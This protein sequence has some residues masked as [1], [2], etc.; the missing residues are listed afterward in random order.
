M[1]QEAQVKH[2]GPKGNTKPVRSRA[3]CGTLNNWTVLEYDTITQHFKDNCSKW[4][5]GEEVGAEGTPHLQLYWE[6]KNPRTFDSIKKIN[7][8]MHFE[9]GYGNAD[10]NKIYC[11][12]G[13]KFATNMLNVEEKILNIKYK[14]VV[15]KD[16]QNAI[17]EN[18]K[19]EV[20][21]RKI[22]WVWDSTGNKGKSFLCKYLSMKFKCIIC[23]GK[24]NDIFN[25]TNNWRV[26]NP[27]EIQIPPCIIDVPRSEYSHINYSAVEQLKNGFLYSGKYEGGKIHGL[28]PHVIIFAN[29]P[30]D[31]NQMS[32]DRWDIREV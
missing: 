18:I 11:S 24:T 4:I 9:K 12:K 31:M 29:S 10:K 25:Q 6:Y 17:I 20:D 27:E 30:P 8:R 21:D 3:W 26:E 13:G 16:W 23:S 32:R 22:I 14:N 5:V 19:G 28:A 2:K 15:W 7:G 1:T